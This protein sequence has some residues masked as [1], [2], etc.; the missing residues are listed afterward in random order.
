MLRFHIFM[1]SVVKAGWRESFLVTPSPSTVRLDERLA[2][3]PPCHS[4][5]KTS[6]ETVSLDR[7]S[8]V[9]FMYSFSVQSMPQKSSVDII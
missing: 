6:Y 8:T 9:F 3:K 5:C 7:F 2:Q 4:R 1:L